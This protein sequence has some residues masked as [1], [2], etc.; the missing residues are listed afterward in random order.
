MAL[1]LCGCG[2]NNNDNSL[3]GSFGDTHS[4][5]FNSVSIVSQTSML[6][7]IYGGSNGAVPAELSVTTTGLNISNGTTLDGNHFLSNVTL[8]RTMADPNDVFPAVTAG[9]ITFNSYNVTQGGS[10][11]GNFSVEFLGGNALLGNFKGSTRVSP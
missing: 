6:N 10:V 5:A 4:L 9:S 3:Q 11:V 8:T 1:L 7:I 2:N